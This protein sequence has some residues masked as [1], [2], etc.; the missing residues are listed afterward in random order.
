MAERISQE[1]GNPRLP[2]PLGQDG[3]A[4]FPTGALPVQHTPL[5]GREQEVAT[6]CTLL[7]RSGV[8]LLTLTGAG[9][10]GKTRLG[11]QA[12][13]ELIEDFADGVCFIPLAPLSDT[14]LVV[15]TIAHAFGLWETEGQLLS[16]LLNAYLRH[17]HLLLVL[18]NFEQVVGAALSVMDLL[19][20]CPQLKV[21][22]TSR[23]VLHVR[24]EHEFP[25]R[26]LSLPD[27]KH[28]PDLAA[29]SQYEA[30]AL[31]IQRAQ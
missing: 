20:A 27:L 22:V 6:V 18:D 23:V 13:T 8:R 9:G 7:R 21:L 26:P 19:D 25:V 30:V 31:F 28:L 29:L 2:H 3:L 16:N 1:F 12:A 4:E 10:V 24:A 11:L 14:E 17:K 5:V 15:P